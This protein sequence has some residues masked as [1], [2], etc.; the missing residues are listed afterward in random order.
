MSWRSSWAGVER[1]RL[2]ALL[3]SLSRLRNRLSLVDAR[4]HA[5]FALARWGQ[6]LDEQL[7]AELAALVAESQSERSRRAC[8]SARSR[9]CRAERS[10]ATA[11]SYA[12]FGS[13]MMP[14]T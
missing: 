4:Q 1:S 9:D 11:G 5:A 3:W 7:V 8:D 12:G 14:A 10:A 13:R 2:S 6:S